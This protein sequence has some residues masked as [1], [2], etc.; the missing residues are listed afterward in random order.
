MVAHGGVD[1]VDLRVIFLGAVLTGRIRS[2]PRFGCSANG[3]P[4]QPWD[5]RPLDASTV[6]GPPERLLP[7]PAWRLA[8]LKPRATALVPAGHTPNTPHRS[9]AVWERSALSRGQGRAC[10]RCAKDYAPGLHCRRCP[11]LATKGICRTREPVTAV[12]V[13]PPRTRHPRW[14]VPR[15]VPPG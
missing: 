4:S 8:E 5:G 2:L 3:G 11:R 10:Q 14:R 9:S 1:L 13:H 7:A 15:L 12:Q 6:R